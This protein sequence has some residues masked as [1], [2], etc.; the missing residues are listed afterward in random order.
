LFFF[1][2]LAVVSPVSLALVQSIDLHARS[3][4]S[5][6]FVWG[7]VFLIAALLNK[8]YGKKILMVCTVL[9]CLLFASRINYLWHIQSLAT[10]ADMADARL[11]YQQVISLPEF[12][13]APK[14]VDIAFVGCLAAE[15]RAWPQDY[16]AIFGLSQFTCFGSS[17]WPAHAGAVLR[18]V[19][20]QIK[21]VPVEGD[22]LIAIANRK[23]WPAVESVFWNQDRFVIWL[24]TPQRHEVAMKQRLQWV[25]SALGL[26]GN[27]YASPGLP[28]PRRGLLQL[29]QQGLGPWE[30]PPLRSAIGHVDDIAPIEGDNHYLR[31]RGWAFDLASKMVPQY[32]ALIT[33]DGKV[34]GLAATGIQRKDLHASVATDA[35]YAGFEGFVLV[36][37]KICNIKY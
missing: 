26:H 25:A 19:G 23:P 4:G 15:T 1:F 16:D 14:P 27:A 35:E 29:V 3:T 22:D 34:A 18:F 21:T 6:A 20:G 24:G 32:V 8:G 2:A 7:A 37:Q 12:S 11:M 28:M 36:D 9:L 5:V 17:T 30:S 33:C 10:E 31:V 13:R